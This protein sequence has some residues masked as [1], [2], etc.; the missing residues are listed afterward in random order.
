[1]VRDSHATRTG[2]DGNVRLG[3]AVPTYYIYVGN[4][5]R[6]SI[7]RRSRDTR[8][9][10][11]ILYKLFGQLLISLVRHLWL[12]YATL[13]AG[14]SGRGEAGPRVSS[15][16]VASTGRRPRWETQTDIRIA[17]QTRTHAHTYSDYGTTD[18]AIYTCIN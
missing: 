1:M 10:L 2:R 3:L 18:G 14:V 7:G 13:R 4:I 15:A 11:P 6:G 16:G 9:P 8:R 17:T 12:K 5:K